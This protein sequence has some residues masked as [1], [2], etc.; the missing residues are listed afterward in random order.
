MIWVTRA[1]GNVDRVA[2]P[3][4]IRRFIDPAAQFLYVP[5]D[6]V[7]ETARL[8]GG[9]SYDAKGSDHTHRPGADG[10][11]E[12]SFVTLMRDHGL[13]GKD[14]ALDL[15]AKSVNHADV[16]PDRTAWKTAEGDGLGAI[17]HGF[18]LLTKDDHQKLAWEFPMY[19]ALYA[20]CKDRVAAGG[21]G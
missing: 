3:W 6:K 7:L 13:W 9:K 16:D 21:K 17:A 2:C 15:L 19:D 5:A 1:G 8:V 4:L 18:A 14:P 12:C 20:W 10:G 11:E